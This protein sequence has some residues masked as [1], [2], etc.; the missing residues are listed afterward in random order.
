MQ[1][2][3]VTIKDIPRSEAVKSHIKQR[4]LKLD[5]YC[6]RIQSCRVVVCLSQKH[7]HQGKLF[8]V[9]IDLHVPGKDL[10]V[11]HKWNEDLYVAIRDAFNAVKRQ[12][13][14]YARKRRGNVKNHESVNIGYIERLF[15]DE[16][17]GFIRSID[18][19]QYYFSMTNVS[20][21]SFT[22]LAIGDM[23]HFLDFVADDGMQAHRVT[24]NKH[25][26]ELIE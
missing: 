9:H 1:A 12:L 22:Q 21:P 26:L 3:Q 16:G 8:R 6:K 24:R 11:N 19:N 4:A 17:Y 14:E 13:E 20:H 23:V 2:L 7:K 10:V 25:Q 5:H 15:F 18:G